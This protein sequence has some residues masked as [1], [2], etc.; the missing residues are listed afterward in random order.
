MNS[1]SV[2]HLSREIAFMTLRTNIGCIHPQMAAVWIDH[3][4]F[5]CAETQV[6]SDLGFDFFGSVGGRYNLDGE[7]RGSLEI[8]IHRLIP[9]GD[10][11]IGLQPVLGTKLIPNLV[12]DPTSD[13]LS[14][15]DPL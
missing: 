2:Q 11:Y 1:L 6:V 9:M 13:P 14:L 7:Q 12:E 8:L 15:H 5:S 3:P 4:D 10:A